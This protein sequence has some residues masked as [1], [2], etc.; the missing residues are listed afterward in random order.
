MKL[1]PRV[2]TNLSDYLE[3]EGCSWMILFPILICSILQTREGLYGKQSQT[4]WIETLKPRLL[5][6][7]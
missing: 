2:T 7:N 5:L 4:I 6:H 3:F 1:F